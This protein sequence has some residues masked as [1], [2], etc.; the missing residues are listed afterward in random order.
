MTP[1]RAVADTNTVVSGLLWGGSPRQVLDA[2]RRGDLQL[3]TSPEMLAE[4]ED[5]LSRPKFAPRLEAAGVTATELVTGY[6]SLAQV[7]RLSAVEPVI[8]DDPD[9][10]VVL[11]T[12]SAARAGVIVS[13]DRHL[14]SLGQHQG[15]AILST[16][17]LLARLQPPPSEPN[18]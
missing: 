15:I 13:G 3:F 5:V 7:V 17:D 14:L 8:A 12:A 11:A 4:L 9:D 10:D 16:A 18:P 1:E 6:A 2:A